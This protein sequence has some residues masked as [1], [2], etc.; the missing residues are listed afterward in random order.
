M[1]DE[2]KDTISQLEEALES[3]DESHEQ[4][5][6]IQKAHEELFEE[7]RKLEEELETQEQE[8]E[9]A[10]EFIEDETIE[11][12]YEEAQSHYD[13]YENNYEQI[14]E[15]FK[16]VNEL[17]DDEKTQLKKLYKKAARLCHPDIV[18]HE[19]KEKATEMMQQLNTAYAKKDLQKAKEILYSLENGTVFERTSD[20]I[21]DKDHLKA[22]IKEYRQ[23]INAI[24]S[25][26]EE[27]KQDD[28]YQ[29]IADLDDWDDYFE[30]LK[31]ELEIEKVRLEEEAIEVLK[32]TNE[33]IKTEKIM[34][35]PK[36]KPTTTIQKE[37]NTPY[38][39][40]ILSIENPNFEKI[41]RYCNNLVDENQADE[42]QEYLAQNGKMHK[43]LIYDA[44]EQFA[45][46]LN[47]ETIT[48]V[49][50]GC[51]QGID[52]MLVIDY[53][54]E[55]QLN[56]KVFHVI[57][58]DDEPKELSR[59]MTQVEALS[60]DKI[61]SIAVQN[62]MSDVLDA[63]ESHENATTL[64]LFA[65]DKMPMDSLDIDYDVFEE[66]YFMCV[67]HESMAFVDE[68]YENMND[69]IDLQELSSR[70]GK[71][72]RFKRFERIFKVGANL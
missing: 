54:R 6:E 49:D 63:L 19:L 50:W 7:L 48:V 2:L 51:G 47:G 35:P 67:S 70:N 24:E 65:N 66:A 41:R 33:E 20:A 40:H 14:K 69:F 37:S 32:E 64:N 46:Q 43:A 30:E 27:L 10:K 72:G 22:K 16:D 52:S 45:A 18:S 38:A 36:A 68:I 21:E 61:K 28:T 71:I 62:R 26:L 3:I 4:Y 11:E 56:I 57:L 15:S 44:L 9:F 17:S 55:K 25:E 39:Q 60:H 42:M 58:I 1:I 34:Q 29:T 31:S 5:D 59:A 23:N 13:E 8:L 12:E 53:I